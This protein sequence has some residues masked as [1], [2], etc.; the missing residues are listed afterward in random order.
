MV[1]ENF[2]NFITWIS[3]AAG[4]FA[5]ILLV[6]VVLGIFFGYVVASFRHGPFEAF[7]VVAQVI[8]QAIPDFLGTSFR[9][10]WAMARL[11]I[12]EAIRR[13][14]ILVSFVIFFCGAVVWR[15]V[16]ELRQ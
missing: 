4:L 9:R 8:A 5:L 12:K 3:G 7:Y 15:L 11:A 14:V 13:R 10:V 2:P 16:H 6:A 1:V